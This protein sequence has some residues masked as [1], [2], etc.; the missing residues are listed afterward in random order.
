MQAMYLNNLFGRVKE[1]IDLL[2]V[3]IEWG[4]SPERPT[5]IYPPLVGRG[6]GGRGTERG[7]TTLTYSFFCSGHQVRF[8]RAGFMT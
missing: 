3:K 5:N 8:A 6:Q 2:L 1:K 4:A 7:S